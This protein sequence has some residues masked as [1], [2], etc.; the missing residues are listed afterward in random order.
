M[1][2]PDCC[3][4]LYS[5]VPFSKRKLTLLKRYIERITSKKHSSVK[6]V[7][8]GQLAAKKFGIY[9]PDRV[10]QYGQGHRRGQE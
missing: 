2:W 3:N 7:E 8:N 4:V 6:T 10:L 9:W 1:T 5:N